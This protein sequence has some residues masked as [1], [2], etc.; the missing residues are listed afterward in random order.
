VIT[1]YTNLK[2]V[3]GRIVLGVLLLIM[4]YIIISYGINASDRP[5][6][7]ALYLMCILFIF[8][9][10]GISLSFFGVLKVYADKSSGELTLVR[11]YSKKT[12]QR[13]EI[14]G[15]YVSVYNTRSGT[16]YGRIIK[17]TNNKITELNPGNLKDVLGIDKYLN[18]L[19]IENLGEKRSHYPFTSGL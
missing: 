10:I 16:S 2:G 9:L 19:S 3:I 18:G 11:F 15:Y 7:W 1:I 6:L 13:S 17:T 8:F 5:P 4:L 14:S 12:I